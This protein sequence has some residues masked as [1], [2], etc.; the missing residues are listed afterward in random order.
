MTSCSVGP[1]AQPLELPSAALESA[2]QQIVEDPLFDHTAALPNDWWALFDDTQLADFIQKA[3]DRSPTLQS[4]RAKI[5]LANSTADRVRANLYPNLLWAADVSRQKLS[6]TGLIPF[7]IAAPGTTGPAP[8]QL[9]ATGGRAHIPVYFTQYETE[10]NFSYDFDVWKKNRNTWRAALGEV[11]AKIADEQFARLELG[12][13]VAQTYFRLQIA[14]SRLKIAYAIVENF[15]KTL[16]LTKQRLQG[17]L[18]NRQTVYVAETNVV[19]AKQSLLQIQGDIAVHENQLRAYLA[20]DFTDSIAAVEVMERSLP[21]V[22]LPTDLPLHLI[23]R[24][25]DITAQLWLIESAGRQIDVAKVGFYPDFSLQALFG[26]QTIHLHELFK[27]PS[28]YYNVD[29][30]VSLPIFDGGRLIANLRYSEVN[31]DEA[32][33]RYNDLVLNAVKEVLDGIA[34]LRIADK[35][36]I[37]YRQ[38]RLHQAEINQLTALRVANHLDSGL[39]AL[40]S[41]RNVLLASEQEMIALGNT[42]QAI[43]TLIKALGG[44]YDICPCIQ[45]L[46]QG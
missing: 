16:A 23:S 15:E 36:Q 10:L 40:Y 22:P 31:Y 30:A 20:E 32:I 29:P 8:A 35:Q 11:R 5:L 38:N 26:F 25:P 28:S 12:A 43:I 34:L 9:A 27:W 1:R 42:L 24:R 14:Y 2:T 4:A 17:N 44:G 45:D 41:E 6:E 46:Q 7:N 39:N 13:A 19:T 37:E 18:D 33:Y 21:Q 3:F